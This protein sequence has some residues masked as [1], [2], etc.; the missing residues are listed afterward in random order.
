MNPNSVFQNRSILNR[1]RCFTYTPCAMP[2][3]LAPIDARYTRILK[4]LE[5]L[6]ALREGFL[7]EGPK[8]PP[9]SDIDASNIFRA[10]HQRSVPPDIGVLISEIAHHL[11]SS[12]D[13]FA[14]QVA[15]PANEKERKAVTFPIHETAPQDA[16]KIANELPGAI[17]EIKDE[18]VKLQ[19]YTA[20]SGERGRLLLILHNLNR[21]DK[22]RRLTESISKLGKTAEWTI[23]DSGKP[24]LG[25]EFYVA[26]ITFE[27]F[28]GSNKVEI[29]N[30][31]R[32]LF[33]NVKLVIGELNKLA[34]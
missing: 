4:T 11:R 13:N 34:P 30:G 31:L 29:V 32:K 28:D 9:T 21:F 15:K 17:K 3:D 24:T 27:D 18:I 23:D 16:L 2:I 10:Y 5:E 25:A 26:R 1:A 22:H 14:W 33:D 6:I 20:G 7:A 8:P 19:P 12:L